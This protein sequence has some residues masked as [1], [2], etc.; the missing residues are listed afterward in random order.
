[1]VAKIHQRTSG[2]LPVIGVGGIMSPQ[3][4]K[5]ML[6]NGATLIQVYTGM[7]YAGPFFVREIL[8]SL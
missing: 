7:I 2:N 1:M 3:D 5:A 4:A 6:A 8:N